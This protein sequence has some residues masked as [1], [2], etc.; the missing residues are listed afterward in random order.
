MLIFAGLFSDAN[1]QIISDIMSVNKIPEVH[2]EELTEKVLEVIKKYIS[3]ETSN[4]N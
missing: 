1:K 4:K 2:R 3:I